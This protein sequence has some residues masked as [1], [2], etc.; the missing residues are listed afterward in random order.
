VIKND[1]TY[2]NLFIF[3]KSLEFIILGRQVAIKIF[4]NSKFKG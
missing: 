1:K 2:K 3:K 4:V